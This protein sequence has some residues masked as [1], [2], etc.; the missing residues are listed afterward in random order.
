MSLSRVI[1]LFICRFSATFNYSDMSHA[2]PPIFAPFLPTAYRDG[3]DFSSR[4][5]L[6]DME[7]QV[8][9]HDQCQS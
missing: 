2:T 4:A 8:L 1:H 9:L 6:I 3:S 5:N 7:L